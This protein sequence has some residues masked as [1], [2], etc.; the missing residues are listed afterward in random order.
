MNL[1]VVCLQKNNK[2]K[3]YKEIEVEIDIYDVLEFLDQASKSEIIQIENKINIEIENKINI[4]SEE[5]E[6]EINIFKFDNLYDR[7]KVLILRKAMEK[8]NLEQLIEKLGILQVD[9]M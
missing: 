2:K 8:Y 6:E 1:L 9:A 7:E 4:E 5:R 3:M